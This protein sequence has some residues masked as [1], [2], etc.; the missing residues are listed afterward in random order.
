MALETLERIRDLKSIEHEYRVALLAMNRLEVQARLDPTVLDNDMRVRGIGEA[1][2]N[3]N[4]TYAIRLF[5]EFETGLRVF[6]VATRNEPEP[7]RV[8][9]IIDR[10]ASRYGIGDEERTNAHRSRSYR[11]RQIHANQEKDETIKV[12]ECRRF[13]CCF[14]GK[15]PSTWPSR[16]P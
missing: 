6:W 15:M 5:A 7:S 8:A 10:I 4:G 14:L 3:L 13:L 12:S 16:I 1:L 2:S 9:E 11:N